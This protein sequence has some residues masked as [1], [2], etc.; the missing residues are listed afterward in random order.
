MAEPADVPRKTFIGYLSLEKHIRNQ[1]EK[2]DQKVAL[3]F[4]GGGVQ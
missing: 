2:R 3:D 1:L 4:V